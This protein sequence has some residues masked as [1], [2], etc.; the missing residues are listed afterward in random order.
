MTRVSCQLTDMKNPGLVRWLFAVALLAFTAVAVGA[1]QSRDGES[2]AGKVT[3]TG[4][5][6]LVPLVSDIA[7]RFEGLHP[8]TK[9]DV[10]SGGVGKG[11]A[12][13]R[14]ATADAAMVPRSL[15]SVERDLFSFPI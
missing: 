11:L 3:I 10:R 2:F 14:A 12:D 4:S 15:R 8:G 9:I 6:L 5:S 1:Q 7:R 13:V